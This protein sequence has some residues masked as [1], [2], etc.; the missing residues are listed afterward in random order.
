LKQTLECTKDG[1]CRQICNLWCILVNKVQKSTTFDEQRYHGLFSI[2][3][4][5]LALFLSKNYRMH[6]RFLYWRSSM[7]VSM[8]WA[9][10]FWNACVKERNG[11]RT[12]I[13]FTIMWVYQLSQLWVKIPTFHK[14]LYPWSLIE[15]FMQLNGDV[16]V[17]MKCIR[18]EPIPFTS[19]KH[20]ASWLMWES[21]TTWAIAH[22]KP[23]ESILV[24][25][26]TY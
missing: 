6:Y 23:Y 8:L 24:S 12:L 16:N 11:F 19:S 13:V 25:G 22:L 14:W 20:I 1:I 10:E 26:K 2:H 3:T 7:R 15:I 17:D 4:I 9:L 21:M 5:N 18:Q